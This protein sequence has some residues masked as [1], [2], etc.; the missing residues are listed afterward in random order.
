MYH[1]ENVCGGSQTG[2]LAVENRL[3]ETQSNMWKC[4]KVLP[5]PGKA[6]RLFI[7]ISLSRD[8]SLGSG[9]WWFRAAADRPMKRWFRTDGG[10]DGK[11]GQHKEQRCECREAEPV[12]QVLQA[13]DERVSPCHWMEKE[14]LWSWLTAWGGKHSH[15]GV[16][17]DRMSVTC[18][19]YN[20]A[21]VISG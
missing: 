13:D 4:L 20:K 18:G 2:R 5:Q 21:S 10:A 8:S 1:S 17:T 9:A 6:L 19:R 11:V 16:E 15:L 7:H 3:V 12:G 14:Q